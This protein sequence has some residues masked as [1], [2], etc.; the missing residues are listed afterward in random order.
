MS[1]DIATTALKKMYLV[2]LGYPEF[3]LQA[4]F[5]PTQL[6]FYYRPSLTLLSYQRGYLLTIR[7]SPL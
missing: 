1:R 2:K 4:Q 3:L 7:S 6:S 5:N